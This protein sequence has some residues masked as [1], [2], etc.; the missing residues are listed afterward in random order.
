M[1]LSATLTSR[2]IAPI[3]KPKLKQLNYENQAKIRL[4]ELHM[5]IKKAILKKRGSVKTYGNPKYG[6][7]YPSNKSLYLQGLIKH[8]A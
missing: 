8:C 2:H 4:T 7:K 1:F 5:P 6:Q 3:P